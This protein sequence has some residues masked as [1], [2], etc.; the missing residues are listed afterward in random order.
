MM[1][2]M[3]RLISIVAILMV[4]SSCSRLLTPLIT[5]K[6]NSEFTELR[7]G[8]YNLDKS[9]AALIFK[10]QH[11]GLSTYVGRFKEFDASLDFDPINLEATQ[12]DAQIQIDSLDINDENL[13]DDLMG[14]AWFNQKSFPVA[15]IKTNN[16]EKVSANQI[17]LI[18]IL[19][20]RGVEKPIELV[21]TFHGGA[22]N[23]LTGKYT[24]GFSAVGSFRRSDF[25]MSQ[26]IPLVGDEVAIEVFGEFQRAK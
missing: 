8:Q 24:L 9:H 26:F 21:A 3:F 6:V 13:K 7:S 15:G 1:A 17:K 10:I 18:T 5:P 12:I 25:G 16:V 14:R 22:T 4:S 20:W 2:R 23:I 19:S 11:M